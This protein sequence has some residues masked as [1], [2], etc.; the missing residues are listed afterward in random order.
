M[1]QH[2]LELCIL[3]EAVLE[4][5]LFTHTWGQGEVIQMACAGNYEGYNPFA[6][7]NMKKLI[8]NAIM[9]SSLPKK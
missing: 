3:K 7:P 6:E 4:M 5:R 1:G 9:I 8:L 2:V